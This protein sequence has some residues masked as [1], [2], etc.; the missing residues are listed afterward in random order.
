M[1]VIA[2]ALVVLVAVGFFA[3]ACNVECKTS[4][5]TSECGTGL[6]C[7]NAGNGLACL[8]ICATETDCGANETCTAVA[9][10][11][12][13]SCHADSTTSGQSGGW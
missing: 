6:V 2:A 9:Q 4:G 5:S 12:L 13:K 11:N 8:K 1:K 10:S 7:D 3:G